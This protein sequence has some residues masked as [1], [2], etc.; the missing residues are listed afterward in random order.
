M[1][2]PQN[3]RDTIKDQLFVV[4]ELPIEKCD[5]THNSKAEIA[6]FGWSKIES[7]EQFEGVTIFKL[8]HY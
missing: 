4:C 5:P 2:D 6:N 7:Y 3:S 1:I 8:I